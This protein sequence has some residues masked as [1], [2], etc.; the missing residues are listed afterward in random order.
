MNSKVKYDI[1]GSFEIKD[2]STTE[3]LV[4]DLFQ[5][6]P[7]EFH[8]MLNFYMQNP[9]HRMLYLKTTKSP[10]SNSLPLCKLSSPQ[11]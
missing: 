10:Y 2:Y 4:K 3:T 8:D 5:S 1:A 9:R 7:A 6:H 11:S